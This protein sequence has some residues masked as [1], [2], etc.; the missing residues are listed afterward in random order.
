VLPAYEHDDQEN[1]DDLVFAPCGHPEI[2]GLVADMPCGKSLC[3]ECRYEHEHGGDCDLCLTFAPEWEDNR[4]AG[5][6]N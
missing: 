3:D 5:W 1:L 4:D 6:E 2:K